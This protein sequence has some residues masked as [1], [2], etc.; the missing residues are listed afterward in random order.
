MWVT[1]YWSVKRYLPKC[2]PTECLGTEKNKN[3]TGKKI[4]KCLVSFFC[5]KRNW[6]EEEE[7]ER[8]RVCVCVRLRKFEFV[9]VCGCV[10][11]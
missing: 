1:H 8:V 7:I 10:R 2:Q 4:L 3:C 9:C 5:R 11:V 6:T